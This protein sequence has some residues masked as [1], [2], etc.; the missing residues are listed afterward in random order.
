MTQFSEQKRK[1][2]DG[3]LSAV[4]G[5]ALKEQAKGWRE[6]YFFA[7]ANAGIFL[8]LAGAMYV[9]EPASRG[10]I[11]FPPA[12]FFL[13]SIFS[14]LLMLRSGGDLAAVSWFVLGSGVYFGF[15]AIGGGL[16]V[17]PHSTYIFGEDTLYLLRVNLLNAGSVILV[18]IA[19]YPFANM[20]RLTSTAHDVPLVDIE[21]SL[22]RALP[23][24]VAVT[25][26]GVALKY[27]LFPVA[28]DLLWRGFAGKIYLI[29]PSC[30]LLAGLL[31]RT[32]NLKLKIII[33]AIFFFEI[34]NGLLALTKYQ[35]I[36]AVM[37]FAV[38]FWLTRR[39]FR[40]LFIS[41]FIVGMT[42]VSIV[43]IVTLGRSHFD[44]DTDKNT[45]GTRSSI[46]IDSV[47]VYYIEDNINTANEFVS[48]NILRP[49]GKH[50]LRPLVN[51]VERWRAEQGADRGTGIVSEIVSE[52]FEKEPVKRDSSGNFKV[53]LEDRLTKEMVAG[54]S[55]NEARVRALG[56]RFD[57]ASIQGY[58]INEFNSGN[59]GRTLVDF[60]AVMIPRALWPEKPIVTRFGVQL[61]EKYYYVPAQTGRQITSAT[62]PSYSGEA[63]WNYGIAGVVVVSILMGVAI[64][65]LTRCWQ[66]AMLGKDL[67]FFLIAYP[68]AIAVSFVES[69]VVG[70]YL[71]EFIIFVVIL[72]FARASFAIINR[73]RKPTYS[74]GQS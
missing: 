60:W 53:G 52:Y 73:F 37:A 46:V 43:P 30:F 5:P 48:K 41:F 57:L 22:Q 35:V 18:L 36:T 29:I 40:T 49:F 50:I 34:V 14:Y 9:L 23:F 31:W 56:R 24:V 12:L 44:Y 21:R 6:A 3:A 61:N 65:W 25:A 42:F 54:M 8:C 33:G 1:L 11:L 67:A 66:A 68:V 28:D 51:I 13:G 32:I 59:P 17:H 55:T 70:T 4:F 71:G 15:G 45:L 2:A 19:A 62:A 7:V 74:V 16:H 10:V 72:L 47:A 39:D 58:L 20:R 63:Y 26:I 38:G 27:I 64:G 69:W